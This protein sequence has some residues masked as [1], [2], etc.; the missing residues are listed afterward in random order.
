MAE[1]DISI[2]SRALVT[3][4]ANPI[5]SFNEGDTGRI[6]SNV[7]PGL[8]DGILSRFPWRFIMTKKSLTRDAAAPAGEW[9][10]SYIIP[11]DALGLGH[12]VFRN[13]SDKISTKD[14]EIFGRRI[15]TD[16]E[17]LILDYKART[18]EGEWPAYF[19]DAMV[20]CICAEIAFAVTDQQNVAA[21]WN[22]KAYGTPG[23]NGMG[24]ALGDALAAD[25]QANVLEG[26]DANYFTD[27]RFTGVY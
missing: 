15:Y 18:S 19:T 11:G 8:R 6:C 26:F 12:A 5:S 17:T 25:G 10:Y 14:F 16:E 3:L 9:S 1:T 21:D 27:A 2:C 13:S 4:G 7:Y 23:E 22:V 24:G 20:Q